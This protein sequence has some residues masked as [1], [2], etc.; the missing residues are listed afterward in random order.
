[1]FLSKNIFDLSLMIKIIL[2]FNIL[3]IFTLLSSYLTISRH[4]I[5]EQLKCE[6]LVHPMGVDTNTPRL[7]W[8]IVSGKSDMRQAAYAV[9]VSESKENIDQ[10]IG[11]VWQS[12]KIESNQ[13]FIKYAGEKLKP[14]TRYYWKVYCWN[15][16]GEQATSTESSYFETGKMEEPWQATWISDGQDTILQPAPYFRKDFHVSKK[17]ANARIYTAVA[18]LIELS[19]NGDKIGDCFLNPMFTRYDKRCL[20]LTYDVT[21][22]LR[23]GGNT[24]G[25]ILGNGWYNFQSYAV[26]GFENAV[27]RNRPTFCLELYLEYVD[28]TSETIYSDTSWKTNLGPIVFNS[29]YTGEHYDAREEFTGW[30]F[31]GFDDKDWIHVI[32]RDVPSTNIISQV[33]EPIRIVDKFKNLKYEKINDSIYLYKLP[34]N[35]AGITK[36][37]IKGERGTVIRLK[38]GE[39]IN[40]NRRVDQSTIDIYSDQKGGLD[41]FQTDIYVLKGEGLEE[42][43]PRFNY[44][45]FKY[46][47]VIAD[48]PVNLDSSNIIAYRINSDVSPIS[49]LHS[50]N[51]L[52]NK[53]WEATN[54]SYISNLH[55]YPTDCPQREKNGWTGDAHIALDAALYNYDAIT[56]YEKWMADHRDAQ[57]DNGM[58]PA[59]IPTAGW[60]YTWG[61]GPDWTSTML[62]VPWSIYLFYGDKQILEDN[63]SN[64]K[65][66]V[67][68]ITSVSV[69]NLTDSGLG[70][71]VPYKTIAD[72]ELLISLY[73]Y[74]DALL[75]S[76]IAAILGE[77]KDSKVYAYLSQ[78][79]KKSINSKFLNKEEGIYAS[80]SQ[81]ELSGP[82]YFG[83]VPEGYKQKVADKLAQR[84]IEDNRHLDVGLLGSKTLLS[85]LSDNGYE[86]LAFEVA[87]Q[88]TYP[89]WGWWIENG[90]TTLYETWRIETETISRNHVMFGEIS[91][92]FFKTLG[93]INIDESNPGFQTIII[94]PR[95]VT[96]LNQFKIEYKSVKGKIISSW[97]RKNNEVLLDIEIPPN[98][99]AKL[100]LPSVESSKITINGESQKDV[101]PSGDGSYIL[102]A[103]SYK[104]KVNKH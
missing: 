87:T 56:I 20:Y 38:H 14:R 76:K 41:P 68:Y 60:G 13:T 24:L 98:T 5:P 37:I 8:K 55:G 9:I 22:N 65:M 40:E 59:I 26:W 25:V 95:F 54:R 27:W 50:S 39:T 28:G 3:S 35:I 43:M 17:V 58:L 44:K 91:A 1:M 19:V 30:N 85:A 12:G 69:N 61:N 90:A 73:Y 74:Q 29:I 49:R 67:D 75:L 18:G 47:E 99:E 15:Q 6:H 32:K 53:I 80:G 70:D 46:V 21:N 66:F 101:M 83:I 11:D 81:A 77:E 33:L 84:V 51:D 88:K 78:N 89:S 102:A 104:I 82:L 36:L 10:G 97:T 92:W 93:G 72:K 103:G 62:I 86:D 48:R 34:E 64:M 16:Y 52:V 100:F 31:P 23:Q 4:F 7:S 45:G 42:F 2:T 79:I 71:W 57:L 96:S 63:Y 94:K